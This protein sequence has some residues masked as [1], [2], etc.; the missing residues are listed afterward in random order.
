VHKELRS[1]IEAAIRAAC[2]ASFTVRAVQPSTGGCIHASYIV[3][4]TA[5]RYFV[6][7]NR[8]ALADAFSAEADGL[9]ALRNAGAN[10]PAVV[11]RSDTPHDAFLVLE[12]LELCPGAPASQEKLGRMLAAVHS[13]KREAYGWHRD[14]YIG[15]TPQKNARHERWS[16]F[17]RDERLGPQ[18]ELA[19]LNG[20]WEVAHAC[21]R[22]CDALDSILADA[23]PRSLLHGDLWRGNAAFL[24]DGTPVVFDPAVYEGDADADVAMTELFGGFSKGFY[25]AYRE[26]LPARDGYALRR[27]LYNLYHVLNHVNLFGGGYAAQASRMAGELLAATR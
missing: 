22:L 11:T 16:G 2:G 4:G 3:E 15:S 8:R 6:K 23:P 10:V 27:T 14:N 19:R 12:Y 21:E 20:H 5:D 24:P 17:W 1:A 13:Q 18:L 26:R 25:A 7:T 9:D